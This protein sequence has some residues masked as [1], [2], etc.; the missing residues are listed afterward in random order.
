MP[1]TDGFDQLEKFLDPNKRIMV[2]LE[3]RLKTLPD[4]NVVLAIIDAIEYTDVD[5]GLV[6]FFEQ[7]QTGGVFVAVNKPVTGL[8]EKIGDSKFVRENVEFIDCISS[9]SGSREVQETHVHYLESPQQLVELSVLVA[10]LLAQFK[11]KKFL[12]VDS[13]STLLIYNKPD[14]VVKLVHSIANKVRV[15]NVQGVFL[16]IKTEENLDIIKIISQFADT[17]IEVRDR[18]AALK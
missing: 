15:E 4:R 16:M 12:V 10:K 7:R 9:L 3:N 8:L 17:V 6:K 11:D 1:K 18:P 13:L 5:S 14:A 2:M